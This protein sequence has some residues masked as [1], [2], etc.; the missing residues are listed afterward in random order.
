MNNHP[1]DDGPAI[2]ITGNP[3]DG[4]QYIGPFASMS[5]AAASGN[6]DGDIEADWWIARLDAGKDSL[7]IPV[8]ADS[9]LHRTAELVAFATQQDRKMCDPRGNG[10]G[11]DAVPPTGDD[12]NDLHAQV[13]ALADVAPA[14]TRTTADSGRRI[15]ATFDP[16]VWVNDNAM[17]VDPQGDTVFDVTEAV[18][19]MGRE[20]ALALKNESHEADELRL[21]EHAPQWIKDWSGPFYVDVEDSIAD[22]FEPEEVE[23]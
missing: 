7:P 19:A 17:S 3:V 8:A 23:Q 5:E 10:S 4:F 9:I 18:L 16:Q 15:T 13:M 12:W 11:E 14:L 6:T 2:I 21:S 22:Y 1:P 20:R